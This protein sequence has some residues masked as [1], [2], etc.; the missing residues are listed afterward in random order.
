MDQD[1]QPRESVQD[2]MTAKE[3]A[4]WLGVSE[5]VLSSNRLPNADVGGRRFYNKYDVAAWLR[6]RQE[7]DA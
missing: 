3:M 5:R 6:R 7:R 2:W 4:D 1:E